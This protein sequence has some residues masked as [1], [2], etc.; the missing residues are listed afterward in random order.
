MTFPSKG[1]VREYVVHLL[2]IE[3]IIRGEFKLRFGRDP[4]VEEL[5]N[6]MGATETHFGRLMERWN[7]SSRPPEQRPVQKSPLELIIDRYPANLHMVN[8]GRI[9][10]KPRFSDAEV[11]RNV[12]DELF[13]LGW[14]RSRGEDAFVLR[15][16]F[17]K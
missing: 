4:S 13:E 6:L 3:E 1:E 17:K 11:Y 9:E 10:L 5:I 16:G 8:E 2:D 12:S 15:E 14:K 7:G